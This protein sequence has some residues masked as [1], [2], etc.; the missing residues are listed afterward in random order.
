MTAQVK[1]IMR[2]FLKRLAAIVTFGGR[3][4]KNALEIN[5]WK[6]ISI[7]TANTK[8]RPGNTS[9]RLKNSTNK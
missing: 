5:K 6:D 1:W 7:T 3:G 2:E 9:C 4:G 8:P